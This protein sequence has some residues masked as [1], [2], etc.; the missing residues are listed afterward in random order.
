MCVLSLCF[1]YKEKKNTETKRTLEKSIIKQHCLL[2]YL[3]FSTKLQS[4][5]IC[6]MNPALYVMCISRDIDKSHEQL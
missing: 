6:H 5:Y 2:K 3:S 4:I 1:L